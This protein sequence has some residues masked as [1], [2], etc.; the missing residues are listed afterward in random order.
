MTEKY[1]LEKVEIEIGGIKYPVKKE[2]PIKR[3]QCNVCEAVTHKIPLDDIGVMDLVTKKEIPSNHNDLNAIEGGSVKKVFRSITYLAC[4][5]SDPDPQVREKRFRVVNR[6]AS[7]LIK[8]GHHIYSPISHTHSIAIQCGLPLG[9]EHWE[10]Y[11]RAFISVSKKMY[12]LKL[13]RWE[14]SAGVTAEIKI[15]REYGVPVEYLDPVQILKKKRGS[16]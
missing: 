14:K 2:V 1:N 13:D 15:A 5:Y 7:L 16:Y 10:Q 6:V 8:Q 3:T 9:W 11:D 12:V 4:P